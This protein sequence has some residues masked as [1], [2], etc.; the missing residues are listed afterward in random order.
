MPQYH[1]GHL[2]KVARINS[3]LSRFPTLKLAGNA[4]GGAGIP[5]SI[6]SGERLPTKFYQSSIE[7]KLISISLQIQPAHSI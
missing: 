6:R 7:P 4:Y 3:L 2:D 1:L 5:D